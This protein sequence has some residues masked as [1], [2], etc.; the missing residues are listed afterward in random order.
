MGDHQSQS[1]LAAITITDSRIRIGEM[2]AKRSIRHR[3]SMK[4]ALA[5]VRL[6]AV[7]FTVAVVVWSAGQGAGAPGPGN[8]PQQKAYAA[9]PVINPEGRSYDSEP[10]LAADSDDEGA[11]WIAW[12]AYLDGNEEIRARRIKNEVAGPLHTVQEK[13]A[14]HSS[15]RILAHGG[16]VWVF[17][18]S[19]RAD[20][21]QI[22]GREFR[23]GRWRPEVTFSDTGQDAIDPSVTMTGDGNL[24]VAWSCFDRGSFVVRS[25][26]SSQGRLGRILTL[27]DP[28]ENAF[29]PQAVTHGKDCWVVW[30]QYHDR[31][32]SIRARKAHPEP[33]VEQRLSPETSNSITPAVLSTPSGLH[34]AWV[35]VADVV[36][37]AGAISQMHTLHMSTLRDG[38]WSLTRNRDGSTAGAE[39]THGLMSKIEPRAV[40]TGGYTGRRRAPMLAQRSGGE[41]WLIWERKSDHRGRTPQVTGELIG[42]PA[43]DGQWE[44]PLILHRGLVDY[45]LPH[46]GKTASGKLGLIASQLPRE[47]RRLYR[48]VTVDLELGEPLEEESWPGW[49]PVSLPDQEPRERHEIAIDG[50]RYTLF[51]ADLHCHS[52]LTA[53]AEGEP[54]ELLF[55]ARDKA[56]LDLV[57][58]TENDFLYDIPL[59]ASEYQRGALS[60]RCFSRDGEFLVLPGFE[61]TA[62]LPYDKD[63]DP[64]ELIHWTPQ[65]LRERPSHPNHRSVIYPSTG[66]PLIRHSDVDNDISKLYQAV[67][68]AGGVAHTQHGMWNHTGHEVEVNVEVTAGRET[69]IN[70]PAMFHRTLDQGYRFGFVGCG[71]S[72][73]RNPGLCG[74]L[75]GI[76]AEKL[77]S[78]AIMEALRQRRVFATNGSRIMIDSRAD[79]VFMGRDTTSDSGDIRLVLRVLGTRPIIMATLFGDGKEIKTYMGDGE[80]LSVA[81]EIK[82]LKKGTHWCYW[83]V[84]QEGSSPQY[85]G[86][87]KVARGNLA[88]SSPH[89]L[90]V[91]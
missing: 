41:V 6:I 64:A 31:C 27:S 3:E 4:S 82:G 15:P 30:D 17:W 76:Y 87:V 50:K 28:A 20:R 63:V 18:S 26:L 40:A 66:G 33:E 7:F 9:G 21:W 51:W 16:A 56:G 44:K 34:M 10:S 37:G 32:Y 25:R 45:H 23:E 42:R 36:G 79:G 48:T 71:D 58:F 5:G 22:V 61:W 72:H 38:K 70:K 89:W 86:N 81:H 91:K 39:L 84:V 85:P 12:H 90:V 74:G 77:A 62:R 88:W 2:N 73:R 69:Y 47:H 68:K 80:R 8:P 11:L 67:E 78:G 75:T 52:N 29:R 60:A 19:K 53:D 65:Q 49:K 57:C 55:Y 14:I 59:T 1:D 83:R 24:L 13:G 46:P 43:N 54:D 35:E